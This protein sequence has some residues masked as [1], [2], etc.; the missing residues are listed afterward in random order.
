MTN[1]FSN[2]EPDDWGTGVDPEVGIG[3][4]HQRISIID[5]LPKGRQPM[6]SA[7]GRYRRGQLAIVFE[8]FYRIVHRLARLVLAS[9]FK[10][11]L[12]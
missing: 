2:Q 10:E 5:L 12:L 3:L 6:V 7:C 1:I 9:N 4:G 8:K 11:I